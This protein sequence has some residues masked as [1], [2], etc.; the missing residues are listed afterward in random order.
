MGGTATLDED[1]WT[2]VEILA[3]DMD[4]TDSKT[5]DLLVAHW[6]MEFAEKI[7][8]EMA[9]DCSVDDERSPGHL[10]EHPEIPF[11]YHLALDVDTCVEVQF[12][13]TLAGNLVENDD[14]LYF[15]VL[16]DWLDGNDFDDS[17]Y[18]S[19]YSHFDDGYLEPLE[20]DFYVLRTDQFLL[21]Y[22]KA[23]IFSMWWWC[24]KLFDLEQRFW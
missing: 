15:W 4:G 3:C 13:W 22:T 18:F 14:N 12:D 6:L 5:F 1:D 2:F 9:F 24:R 17:S 11:D 8:F 23:P 7:G 19:N 10:I 20:H 21:L 16:F